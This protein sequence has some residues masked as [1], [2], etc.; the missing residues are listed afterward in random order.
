MNSNADYIFTSESVAAG[1]PDK[2]C[3]QIADAILDFYLS[4]DPTAKVAIEILATINHLVIAGEVSSARVSLNHQALQTIARE[5]IRDIGYTSK[6]F[7]WSEVPIDVYVHHQSPDIAMGVN[8]EH[9]GAGDQGIMFGFATDETSGY[10]PA[11]LFYSH[12]LLFNLNQ[13][14]LANTGP[15]PNS[16]GPDAKAQ[17]SIQYKNHRPEWVTAV[18]LSTQHSA[19]LDLE[20][21]KQIVMPV[22]YSSFPEGWLR[23]ETKFFINP[24]GRFV[25]GGPEGDTGLTGRKIIVDSYGGSAP[26]GG[27][28][29][30]GKDPSKVDRSAAYMARYIAKNIV[31]AKLANKCTVQLAYAI[32]VEEPVSLMI[33]T[34]DRLYPTAALTALSQFIFAELKLTPRAIREHLGLNRPIYRRTAAYGHFG[35]ACDADGGF[36]WERTD[37]IEKLQAFS[38]R[39]MQP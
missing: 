12:K 31:A 38:K 5:V 16:L 29:F 23:P 6:N 3:D 33:D 1:H 22:I 37:L 20:A 30:S 8:E 17:V 35:R 26:H 7:N 32:G 14:R 4:A 2:M 18:V 27:G 39:E 19:A 21:V 36:S 28:A 34:H 10:M 24:T 25:I 9:W 11:P 13:L 15:V